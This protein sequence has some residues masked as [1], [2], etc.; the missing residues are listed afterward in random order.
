MHTL[1]VIFTGILLLALCLL[2]RRWIGGAAA[3]VVATT[4]KYF[5]VLWLVASLVNMWVGVNKGGYSVKNEA[6]LLCSFLRS[7]RSLPLSFGGDSL[8]PRLDN[9]SNRAKHGE[10]ADHERLR[11]K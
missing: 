7:L 2:L 1:K 4:V 5:L 9:C 8:L 6:Q 3:V 11:R 10:F